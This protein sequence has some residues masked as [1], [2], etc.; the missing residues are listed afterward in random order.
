MKRITAK[1]GNSYGINDGN[2]K[3]TYKVYIGPELQGGD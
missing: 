3:A 1:Y 2:G